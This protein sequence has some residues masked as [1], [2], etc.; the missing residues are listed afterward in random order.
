[1]EH[2]NATIGKLYL[3]NRKA[4]SALSLLFERIRD[5]TPPS[6]SGNQRSVLAKN[7][8]PSC[9]LKL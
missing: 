2:P 4:A 9:Q 7:R 3:A 1:M 5:R 6:G 8:C